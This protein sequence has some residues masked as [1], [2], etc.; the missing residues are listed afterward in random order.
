[1]QIRLSSGFTLLE[2]VVALALL[3]VVTVGVVRLFAVAIEAGRAARDRTIAVSLATGKLEQ[4][5]SLEWRLELNTAGV[6]APRT[7]TSTNLSLDPVSGGGPGLSESPVGTLDTNMPP[8][9]DY[10]DRHGR[11]AGTGTS[12]PGNALYVRR[13][14]VHRLPAD[15]DRVV[16]LQVFVATVQ[17]ERSRR[18]SAPHVWNGEDVLLATMMMRRVR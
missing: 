11:W 14:A 3:V 10:L 18:G 4:L 5:R 7:D 2:V 12:P 1:M 8:Y 16:V 9:V 6:L 13:W 15:P 17:R